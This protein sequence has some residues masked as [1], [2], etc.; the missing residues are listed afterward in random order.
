MRRRE[1]VL[2]VAAAINGVIGNNNQLIWNLPDDL[3]RFRQITMGHPILMGRNTFESIGKP[4]PGRR[5]IVVST[6]MQPRMGVEVYDTIEKALEM[7]SDYDIVCV[8]G[9]GQIYAQL[10]PFANRIFLT[11]VDCFP[12][13]DTFFEFDREEW[14]I[15]KE[16]YHLTDDR[17][18]FPFHFQEWVRKYR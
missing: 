14:V 5:N 18:A 11:L 2:V 12:E 1:I 15:L 16:E 13:G 10:L 3:K 6:S 8:I 17:H 9:G 4:L 7:L